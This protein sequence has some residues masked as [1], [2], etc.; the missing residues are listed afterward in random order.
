MDSKKRN[1]NLFIIIVSYNGTLW[2]ERCLSSCAHHNI[3]V[4]DNGS[5]D[6]TVATIKRKFPEVIMFEME[7]NLGFGQANNVGMAHALKNGAEHVFLLNQDAYL[8]DDVIERLKAFQ[9]NNQ[10]YGILSPIHINGEQNKLDR[11]FFKYALKAEKDNFISDSVMD[12]LLK[13]VY[14][15]PFINAAA[16][17]ISK[18]CLETVGGF[19]PIFFHY[20]EDVNYCQRV[21]FHKFKIGIIPNTYVIHDREARTKEIPKPFS[22]AYYTKYER[23]QK[24]VLANINRNDI[25]KQ[26]KFRFRFLNGLLL[27][28]IL[29]CN[30][31]EVSESVLKRRILK[32][33]EREI[34]QS[35][36]LNTQ[37]KANYLKL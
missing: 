33:I 29:K 35:R 15:V 28:G 21:L 24:L 14:D 30:R 20:G 26:L 12:K 11:G 31:H 4:V 1:E 2:I 19:D 3:I 6:A 7:E 23:H 16:W 27:K 36:N 22:R 5:T 32:T 37:E 18:R 10:E 13:P 9:K 8:V 34:L 17:L 25:S